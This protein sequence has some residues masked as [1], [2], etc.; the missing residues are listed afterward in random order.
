M[1]KLKKCATS[2][3][4]AVCANATCYPKENPM[5]APNRLT[6]SPCC[7]LVRAVPGRRFW[8]KSGLCFGRGRTASGQQQAW[9]WFRKLLVV[10]SLMFKEHAVHNAVN[11]IWMKRFRLSSEQV[12]CRFFWP[13]TNLFNTRA[14]CQI[15]SW[16]AIVFFLSDIMLH[17]SHMFFG[18][19]GQP[20]WH[21]RT[22]LSREPLFAKNV[23]VLKVGF[24]FFFDPALRPQKPL[25]VY[26]YIKHVQS[27]GGHVLQVRDEGS[28]QTD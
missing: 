11:I 6:W 24:G 3:S 19:F 18:N 26:M 25:T 15:L 17:G 20:L 2:W 8:R 10:S 14:V 12:L 13:S 21:G 28:Y 23:P 9:F 22:I 16:Y 7:I 5:D 27:K 4:T 1:L